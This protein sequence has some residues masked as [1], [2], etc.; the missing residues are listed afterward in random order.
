MGN[1]PDYEP[2][3]EKSVAAIA[4]REGRSPEE[5]A[6]DYMSRRASICISRW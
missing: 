1:P 4:Q 6:Y 3:P 2:G 5:V